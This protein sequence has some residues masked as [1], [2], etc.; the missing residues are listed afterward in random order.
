MVLIERLAQYRNADMRRV[1][2]TVRRLQQ[3]ILNR[4]IAQQK[5][6]FEGN[7]SKHIGMRYI[8]ENSNKLKPNSVNF[9]Y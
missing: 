3:N 7:H 1:K 4:G 8:L 5:K 6:T 9:V 2:S